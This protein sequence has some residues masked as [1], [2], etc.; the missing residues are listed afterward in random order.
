MGLLDKFTKN[1]G[2]AGK[3]QDLRR[4]HGDKVDKGIDKAAEAARGKHDD[5][6]AK[7]AKALK[8]GRAKLDGDPSSRRRPNN[9]VPDGQ[10]PAGPNALSRRRRARR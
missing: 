10:A 3:A 7:G 8:D 2:T 1:R 5:K 9:P 4:K 6:I